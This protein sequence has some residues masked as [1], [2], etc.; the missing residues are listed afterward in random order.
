MFYFYIVKFIESLFLLPGL[1]I[2]LLLVAAASILWSSKR[3]DAVNSAPTDNANSRHEPS[4]RLPKGRFLR[5]RVYASFVIAVAL[6]LYL[7]S[8]SFVAYALIRPLE[9]SYS[10]PKTLNGD[11]L[12]MLGAGATF[13]TPS[14]TS[15]G[16]LSGDGANRLLTTALLYKETQLPIILTG[17]PVRDGTSPSLIAKANLVRL[18]V[19]SNRVFIDNHSL[20]TRQNAIHTKAILKHLG[21]SHP[22]LIT[23]AYH[24]RR[25]VLDFRNA[26]VQV[27]P[28]PC[29]YYANEDKS[30]SYNSFFPSA[31]ALK[32]TETAIHEYVGILAAKMRIAG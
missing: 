28:F 14:I 16:N 17:L 31:D 26:G 13:G 15:L 19:P 30:I 5:V 21:L 11:A 1:F 32:I 20:D 18:G 9:Q 24:M 4:I 29:G 10:P 23:S 3:R 8:T 6:I 27:L 12:V 2:V 22:I 7:S 25:A